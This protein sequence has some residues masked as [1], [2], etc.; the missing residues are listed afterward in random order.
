LQ[1]VLCKH[2]SLAVKAVWCGTK[3]ELAVMKEHHFH[4]AFRTAA[5]RRSQH[6]QRDALY[7]IFVRHESAE[8]LLA[9][10]LAAGWP[11]PTPDSGSALEWLQAEGLW[12]PGA[13]VDGAL[14]SAGLR[15]GIDCRHA[16]RADGQPMA[17]A[18][19]GVV[20]RCR[21]LGVWR[22]HQVATTSETAQ[23][24]LQSPSQPRIAC[25]RGECL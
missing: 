22:A 14:L 18:A 5:A 6:T 11:L 1:K 8:D 4:K 17:M 7:A 25:Q 2:G 15:K 16:A 9:H 12:K 20:V 10:V 13:T 3:A 21:C 19:L 23:S 24:L